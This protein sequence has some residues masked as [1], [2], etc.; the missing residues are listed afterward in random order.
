MLF[1]SRHDVD[2]GSP[3]EPVGVALGETPGH[4]EERARVLAAQ[5]TEETKGVAVGAGRHRAGVEHDD[6]GGPAGKR[7]REARR[8]EVA[9]EDVGLDLGD[10]AAENVDGV[11]SASRAGRRVR[12]AGLR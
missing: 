10:L 8:L 6:V 1:R 9:G 5:A 2:L 3:G 11:R 4:G 12:T 7:S